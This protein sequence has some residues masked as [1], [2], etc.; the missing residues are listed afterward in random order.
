MAPEEI[1][2]RR[3]ALLAAQ[4][5]GGLPDDTYMLEG[6]ACD[7]F[8]LGLVAYQFLTSHFPFPRLMASQEYH[9]HFLP[10]D[11]LDQ[12][13][14]LAAAYDDWMVGFLL[15]SLVQQRCIAIQAGLNINSTTHCPG[16]F[17]SPPRKT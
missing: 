1:F 10:L 15:M 5:S 2:H 3:T 11:R 7:N 16:N 6:R 13:E 14:M 4:L 8:S 12:L 17:T 9:T